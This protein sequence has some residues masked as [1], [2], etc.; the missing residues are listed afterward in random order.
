MRCPLP[1]PVDTRFRVLHT[2]GIHEVALSYCGCAR[3]IPWHLQLLRRGLYPATQ[4]N[5]RTC[6]SFE[7]L[8]LLHMLS[9]TAKVSTYDFYRGLEALTPGATLARPK[10]R[11]RPLLRVLTQWRHLKMLKRAGR[12]HNPSRA[13]GTKAGELAIL[14]PSCPHPGI[15]LLDNWEEGPI[16]QK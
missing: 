11:Y 3:E 15:N 6:I 7:L 4:H 8:H 14:C 9:L 10:M 12:G 1:T 16:E 2:N 13:I 5:A